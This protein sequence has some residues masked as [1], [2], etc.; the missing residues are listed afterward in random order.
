MSG[1]N[2]SAYQIKSNIASYPYI[3]LSKADISTSQKLEFS[4]KYPFIIIFILT[5]RPEWRVDVTI[6]FNNISFQYSLLKLK[7]ANIL[8]KG[9]SFQDKIGTDQRD[10]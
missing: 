8:L 9:E 10:G 6:Y 3:S 2:R 1:N 5:N 4:L 7:R